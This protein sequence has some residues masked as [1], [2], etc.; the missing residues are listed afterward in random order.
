MEFTVMVPAGIGDFSWMYSKLCNVPEDIKMNFSAAG[1]YP[2][3]ITSFLDLLPRVNRSFYGDHGFE[4]ICL[5]QK[6]QGFK[7][8]KDI[9]ESGRD[10]I[11]LENNMWLEN[12]KRLET[13]LPDLKCNFHYPIKRNSTDA[14]R[15]LD[16]I[17]FAGN[18][19]KKYIGIGMGNKRGAEIWNAWNPE[20]WAFMCNLIRTEF[21]NCVFVM[22]GGHWDKDYALEI[23]YFLT[24]EGIDFIDLVGKTTISMAI[25]ILDLIDMYIGFSSGLN[26]IC[27]VIGTP[28][29][30]LFPDHHWGLQWSWA[31]PADIDKGMYFGLLWD[32]PMNIFRRIYFKLEEVFSNVSKKEV[33]T[34]GK[35]IQM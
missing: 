22:L 15:A 6:E 16:L 7:T 3:R 12:G 5:M 19:G 30:M 17:N 14:M 32:E 1:V 29:C 8:W 9:I 21:S 2:N 23:K 31:D 20:K 10:H 11:W 26:V 28:T 18:E 4:D 13:W 33:T 35:V 34:T 27:T 25:E 24:K